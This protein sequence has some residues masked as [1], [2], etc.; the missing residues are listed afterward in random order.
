ME[1]PIIPIEFDDILDNYEE[2]L[3]NSNIF[4]NNENLESINC[5]MFF[6]SK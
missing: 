6:I 1:E 3:R 4:K 5:Y 2:H